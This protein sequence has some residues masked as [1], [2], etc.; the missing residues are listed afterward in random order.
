MKED[1][2]KINN[3]KHH[4]MQISGRKFFSMIPPAWQIWIILQMYNLGG[5]N[6]SFLPNRNYV[7]T[8]FQMYNSLWLIL[9]KI[10][11]IVPKKKKN[12]LN[13]S[14]CVFT[15]S[16]DKRQFIYAAYGLPC[17]STLWQPSFLFFF[18]Y[19]HLLNLV[20]MLG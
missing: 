7:F 3:E 1:V 19:L 20:W 17:Q 8:A 18:F 5:N 16:F 12:N 6:A 14:L 10:V 15:I 2:I 4:L 13:K 9:T 11:F